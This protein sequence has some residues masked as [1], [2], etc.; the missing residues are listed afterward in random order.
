MWAMEQRGMPFDRRQQDDDA[1]HITMR[2][3]DGLKHAPVLQDFPHI[4][5]LHE[6]FDR[7]DAPVAIGPEDDSCIIRNECLVATFNYSK[8]EA[9][10]CEHA[11]PP[12][13]LLQLITTSVMLIL[14]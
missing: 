1:G 7:S 3:D 8:G 6:L 5:G 4:I 10:Y 13:Q 12:H 2:R 9:C 14:A 11:H